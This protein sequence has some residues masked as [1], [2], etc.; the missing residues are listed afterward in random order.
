[1]SEFSLK[2]RGVRGSYPISSKDFLEYGGNT[3][4]I[5]VNVGGH[6]IILDAGTGMISVGDELM[7]KY[8]TSGFTPEER[9]P[10]RAT[11]LLSHIHQDHIQGFTFFRP[12]HLKSTVL[13][14]FGSVCEE[15]NL[16]DELSNVLFGKTFQQF[17]GR[18]FRQMGQNQRRHVRRLFFQQQKQLR[19]VGIR[20]K[21]K[22]FFHRIRN[23]LLQ[24]RPAFFRPES[25]FENHPRRIDAAARINQ[26]VFERLE[27]PQNHQ[28][29]LRLNAGNGA[30]FADQVGNFRRSQLI[31]NGAGGLFAQQHEEFRRLA[32]AFDFQ[33]VFDQSGRFGAVEMR[34][35]T[36]GSK[37]L[38]FDVFVNLLTQFFQIKAVI[39]TLRIKNFLTGTRL[40]FG[41]DCPRGLRRFCSGRQRGVLRFWF[42]RSARR[43]PLHFFINI[44][45]SAFPPADIIFSSD[46]IIISG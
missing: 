14:V 35:I 18:L 46:N 23:R 17:G 6:L 42:R 24:K 19:R 11:V 30:H 38:P 26:A 3:A 45:S 7:E 43:H 15:E 21:R 27:F 44:N 32:H 9:T 16:S 4:C 22:R 39:L 41:K 40:Q 29:L 20:Q 34:R 37:A 10:V 31:Q 5:E 12:L 36:V 25:V 1:M 8:I 28:R 2:F 33:S 13:S